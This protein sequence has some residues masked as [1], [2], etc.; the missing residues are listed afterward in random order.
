MCVHAFYLEPHVTS[1]NNLRTFFLQA[2]DIEYLGRRRHGT[3]PEE[4]V[5]TQEQK[6]ATMI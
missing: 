5:P 6:L 1:L 2:G 4:G 3:F